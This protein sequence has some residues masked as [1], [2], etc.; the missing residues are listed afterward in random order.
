[1]EDLYIGLGSNLGNREVLLRRA[2]KI[3]EER[4]GGHCRLSAF[5]ETEPWGFRSENKFLNAVAGK[6]SPRQTNPTG[7]GIPCPDPGT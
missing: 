6:A 2:A 3:L 1:M 7:R 5:Y 4:I